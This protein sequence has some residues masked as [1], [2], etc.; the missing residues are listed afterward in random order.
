MSSVSDDMI[1]QYLGFLTT[2][3]KDDILREYVDNDCLQVINMFSNPLNDDDSLTDIYD[4]IIDN[5]SYKINSENKTVNINF[6][7]NQFSLNYSNDYYF[8]FINENRQE[9]L[10]RERLLF[11]LFN[12]YLS[13]KLFKDYDFYCETLKNETHE[14]LYD[15]WCYIYPIINK[16][17]IGTIISYFGFDENEI[18]SL[19]KYIVYNIRAM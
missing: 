17:I 7:D 2:N 19:S 3:E 4:D 9:R 10:Q 16:N 18:S 15:T 5:I 13:S 14:Y 1:Q 6:F 12:S 11:Y 8:A